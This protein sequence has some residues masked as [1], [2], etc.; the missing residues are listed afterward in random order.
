M[1]VSARPNESRIR[2]RVI[3]FERA[4]DGWG[5]W[6]EL[7]VHSVSAEGTERPPPLVGKTV[8]TFVPPPMVDEI[9]TAREVDARVSWHGGPGGGFYSLVPR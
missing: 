8:R 3:R 7:D 1:T 2:G 5:G 9:S 6:A 4:D